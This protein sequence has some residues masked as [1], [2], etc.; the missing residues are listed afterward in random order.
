MWAVSLGR[1][2]TGHMLRN[3][4]CSCSL[5]TICPEGLRSHTVCHR[6]P[7]CVAQR[8]QDGMG[9]KC[10]ALPHA[11][12]RRQRRRRQAPRSCAGAL[13]AATGSSRQGCG[14]SATAGSTSDCECVV[15]S[16]CRAAAGPRAPC[17]PRR[18]ALVFLPQK[19][20]SKLSPP[21]SR[22]RRLQTLTCRPHTCWRP[23]R[24][25]APSPRGSAA[26]SSEGRPVQRR[27]RACRGSRRRPV[28]RAPRPRHCRPPPTPP[29]PPCAAARLQKSSCCSIT[30]QGSWVTPAAAGPWMRASGPRPRLF[31]C[32][33]SRGR[34]ITA[35]GRG[36]GRGWA[37]PRLRVCPFP[38][39]PPMRGAKGPLGALP[40]LRPGPPGLPAS[41][42]PHW[43]AACGPAPAWRITRQRGAGASTATPSPLLYATGH[44]GAHGLDKPGQPLR[45]PL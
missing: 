10:A 15:S 9:E 17:L 1:H 42:T 7:T 26:P 20:S 33:A 23:R 36:S 6:E 5:H 22:F 25:P 41:G 38:R 45:V 14:W 8:W 21:V 34:V 24:R 39:P 43:V 3:I 12:R 29:R 13:S 27:E 19:R 37:P 4:L 28:T 35:C 11:R 16:P 30:R 2:R 32:P 40:A 44:G 18:P 31:L